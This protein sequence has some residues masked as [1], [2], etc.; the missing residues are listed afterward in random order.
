VNNDSVGNRVTMQDTTGAY[1]TTFD[2]LDRK[3]TGSSPIFVVAA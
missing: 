1:T 3:R 2:A